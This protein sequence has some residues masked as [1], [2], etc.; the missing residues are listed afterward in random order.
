MTSDEIITTE[1]EVAT[2]ASELDLADP[3]EDIA[4]EASEPAE[5]I[6]TEDPFAV[7]Q[8]IVLILKER[9]NDVEV[10]IQRNRRIWAEV[11]R[12]RFLEL[13]TFLHDELGFNSLCTVTALD[14]G[15]QFQLIY[16]LA[17]ENGMVLNV[18][19]NAPRSQPQ[20]ETATNIYKGGVLY[21]LEAR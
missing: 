20:F 6:A 21:E 9:F 3:A 15:D 7:E 17:A 2:E 19:Q 18:K 13:L 14:L 4:I 5:D 10:T 12:R 1:E 16:H 8:D 11:S